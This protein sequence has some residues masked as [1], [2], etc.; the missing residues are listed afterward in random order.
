M[1]IFS[2]SVDEQPS[3]EENK[4]NKDDYIEHE[5]QLRVQAEQFRSLQAKLNLLIGTGLTGIL[6]P[7]VL[8]ILRMV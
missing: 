1:G 3:H 6:I 8:H 7:V 5:V 4:M 2:N